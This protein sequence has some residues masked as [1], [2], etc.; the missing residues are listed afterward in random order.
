MALVLLIAF[1]LAACAEGPAA[2]FD[3][4]GACTADGSAPGAYPDLEALVPTAYEGR[5][6]YTLDSGRNCTP[7]NLGTLAAAGIDEVRFAG[8]TWDF[9]GERAAAL[10]VF[11][12]PGLTADGIAEFYASSAQGSGRTQILA[13]STPTLT[14]RSGHR[15]DTKSGERL[16]TVVAWPSATADTVNVV[17]TNDLPDPKIQAAVDA[18]GGD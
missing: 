10:V 6:P 1:V 18:F 12:A 2:S 15:L 8:G 5:G 17:I 16:Q 14:G 4:T 3:P 13:V 9:G 11:Q 7:A